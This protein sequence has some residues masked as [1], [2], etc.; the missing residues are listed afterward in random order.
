MAMTPQDVADSINAAGF[1]AQDL[2][3]LLAYAAPVFEINQ[4]QSKIK[5]LEDAKAKA[6]A[7][8]DA[9]IVAEQNA[10]DALDRAIRPN[11]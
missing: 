6:M 3:N 1:T 9:L 4:R 7:E 10:I 11:L 2:V 5:A 8:Y